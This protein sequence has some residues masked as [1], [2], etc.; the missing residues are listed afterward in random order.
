[1]LEESC[2]IYCEEEKLISNNQYSIKLKTELLPSQLLKVDCD[3]LDLQ[4]SEDHKLGN[5]TVNIEYDETLTTLVEG[6]SNLK[7]IVHG[8]N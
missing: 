2:A 7:L 6:N 3:I 1:M 8:K 4:T 5:Q